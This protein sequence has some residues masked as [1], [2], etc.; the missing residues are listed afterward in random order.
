MNI[1]VINL[2]DLIK[3]GCI[4]ILLVIL[5]ISGILII[6]EKEELNPK[7]ILDRLS[8]SSFLYCLDN[9]IPLMNNKE[10]KENKKSN[11]YHILDMELAMFNNVKEG[12]N[13]E[14]STI[15]ENGNSNEENTENSKEE[16]KDIIGRENVETKVISE[17]NI[18]ASFT[19]ENNGIKI[20]NQSKYDV[21]DLLENSNYEIKNKEKVV[22]Y[23]THTCESYTSSE[24]Y[25]Y[26][27]TGVYRTT[28]LNYTVA[29]VRRR[30]RRMFKTIW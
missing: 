8:N 16:V 10:V 12:E 6:K 5:L 22:I 21:R 20:K 24:K 15:D 28:D 4:F 1:A 29:R 13:K 2:R 26:Q 3:Y 25:P 11:N 9:E 7:N 19:Y 18:E 30:V 23:H 27:M 17:N 14:I